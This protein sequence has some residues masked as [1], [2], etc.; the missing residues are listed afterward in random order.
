VEFP[1]WPVTITTTAAIAATTATAAAVTTMMVLR[2]FGAR[3]CPDGGC[4]PAPMTGSGAVEGS[5][6]YH[7]PD[8]LWSPESLVTHATVPTRPGWH[9][10]RDKIRQ[11]TDVL[12]CKLHHYFLGNRADYSRY[13]PPEPA[14]ATDQLEPAPKEFR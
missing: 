12:H 1:L 9:K 5:D 13:V 10:R 11:L 4:P 14:A 3:P 6:A 2:R 7:G 8:I